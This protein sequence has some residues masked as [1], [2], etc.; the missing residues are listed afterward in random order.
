MIIISNCFVVL[1]LKEKDMTK[2]SIIYWSG[3]GNTEA[4]AEFISNGAQQGGAEVTQI[5]VADA[6]LN[7]VKSAD[8]VVFGCPA[9]GDEVLEESEMEPFIDSIASAIEGKKV[10][11]FGSYGWGDGQW[12]RDWSERMQNYGADLIDDEGFI[13]NGSPEAE[14]SACVN[15]G[16]KIAA[17]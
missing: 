8:I 12:M 1:T 5:N 15:Y 7:D 2:V 4:M 6:S 13:V 3:T 10:A 16:K 17:V 9:M 14:E 11:L